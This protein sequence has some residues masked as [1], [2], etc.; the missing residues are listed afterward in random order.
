MEAH[1][2]RLSFRAAVANNCLGDPLSSGNDVGRDLRHVDRCGHDFSVH[3]SPVDRRSNDLVL[4]LCLVGSRWD[5]LGSGDYLRLFGCLVVRD[6]SGNLHCLVVLLGHGCRDIDWCLYTR[7][8]CHGLGLGVPAGT[9]FRARF[10]AARSRVNWRR[11]AWLGY[12]EMGSF[13]FFAADADRG[14]ELNM[15]TYATLF[16]GLICSSA[17]SCLHD[18]G[19]ASVTLG[20]S[21]VCAI[22]GNHA[23]DLARPTELCIVILGISSL[24]VVD[25]L[26]LELALDGGRDA[27]VSVCRSTVCVWQR[28]RPESI[29]RGL[30]IVLCNVLETLIEICEGSVDRVFAGSSDYL[31]VVPCALLDTGCLARVLGSVRQRWLGSSHRRALRRL[32]CLR[33]WPSGRRRIL[34]RWTPASPG[35][36][37]YRGTSNKT[38]GC[39]RSREGRH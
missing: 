3:L 12:P 5:Q 13:P 32:A 39:S 26:V 36:T 25:F 16:C 8:A 27:I 4:R 14:L 19:L 7:P 18:R 15:T 28:P 29:G 38:A 11:Q 33:T 35:Q 31:M 2:G 17:S 6:G 22:T 10:R 24:P 34:G 9:R 37:P 1:G 30:T 21:V 23:D 20:F